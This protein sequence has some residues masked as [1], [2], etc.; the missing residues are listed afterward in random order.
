MQEE[1]PFPFSTLEK[2]ADILLQADQIPL[3]TA[4]FVF[5]MEEF[6]RDLA[7]LFEGKELHIS[8]KPMIWKTK[9]ELLHSIGENSS[10]IPLLLS[11]L[12]GEALWIMSQ[13]DIY[14]L[15]SFTLF[16]NGEAKG[17]LS[18]V[19]EEGYFRYLFLECLL[20]LSKREPF[21]SFSLK[22]SDSTDLKDSAYL[23]QDLHFTIDG[24]ACFAR[25]ALSSTFQKSWEKHFSSTATLFSEKIA[26][27][28]DL[29]LSI[30]TR[31]TSILPSLWKTLSVGD[32]F[33]LDATGYDPKKEQFSLLI[34]LGD[35][36][37]F[38]AKREDNSIQLTNHA[39][40]HEET[41]MEDT[42]KPTSPTEVLEN[43][44]INIVVELGRIAMTLQKLS[45]LQPGN[46][47]EIPP[48]DNQVSLMVNGK[49]V[50]KGELVYIGEALGVRIQDLN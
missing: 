38:E 15:V 20:L 21:S 5:S 16:K 9:E 3:L 42:K 7:P 50:A 49:R 28:V 26:S 23:C 14:K 2:I 6:A 4:P 37:L 12:K 8:S 36:L 46:F 40:I 31:P 43:I 41:P 11:P 27:S 1:K 34:A 25:L 45:Q 10:Q 22:I 48:F 13:A 44:P 39:S 18:D 33:L 17:F 30:Q 35:L 19:L 29:L 32:F 47:L 24:H